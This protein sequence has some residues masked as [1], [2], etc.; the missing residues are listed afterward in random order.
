MDV[1]LVSIFLLVVVFLI[2]IWFNTQNTINT[3]G[4]TLEIINDN[5]KQKQVQ[6]TDTVNIV[7]DNDVLL[8]SDLNS[9][10]KD[11]LY[12]SK[13]YILDGNSISFFFQILSFFTLGLGL[14]VLDKGNKTIDKANKYTGRLFLINNTNTILRYCEAINY[15]SINIDEDD[16]ISPAEQYNNKNLDYCHLISKN[17]DDLVN[18]IKK[19]QINEIT[20]NK[21]KKIM[22]DLINGVRYKF[23]KLKETKGF[24]QQMTNDIEDLVERLELLN[25]EEDLK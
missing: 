23:N 5:V 20:S 13:K 10:L 15:Y 25:Y 24:Y 19:K 3:F 1:L 18:F 14:Y 12:K 7:E 22:L 8:N 11:Q 6:G 21:E 16:S 4:A 2:I 9:A 17:I